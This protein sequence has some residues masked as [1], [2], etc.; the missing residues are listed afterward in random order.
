MATNLEEMLDELA[1]GELEEILERYRRTTF[2]S[3][4][5]L[6]RTADS[7]VQDNSVTF[8]FREYA[9]FLDQ[10]TRYIRAQPFI[11]PV[12]D[13]DDGSIEDLLTNAFEQDI[14]DAI[15]TTARQGGAT[16]T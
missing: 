2:S 13:D 3:P 9:E 16:I 11:T 12:L 1:N 5:F 8:Q 10:G 15:N 14:D 7:F 6:E 4:S